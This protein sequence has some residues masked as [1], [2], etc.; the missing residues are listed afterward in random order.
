MDRKCINLAAQ[1]KDKWRAGCSEQGSEHAFTHLPIEMRRLSFYLFIF[2]AYGLLF[3]L[4][5]AIEFSLGGS[6]LHTS[7]DKTN[8]N[9]FDVFFR[10]YIFSTVYHSIELFHQPT[11]MPSFLYSLTI[12]LLHY[13]PR[14]VSSINMPK[15]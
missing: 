9:K 5:T 2:F 8:K 13:C 15:F 12:C 4:L 14:H 3:L 6:S 11:L 1:K 7:T 10:F